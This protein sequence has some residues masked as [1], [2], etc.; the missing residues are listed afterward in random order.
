MLPSRLED[1]PTSLSKTIIT[2]QL[3][4][5]MPA[6]VFSGHVLHALMSVAPSTDDAVP[7]PQAIETQT[8]TQT[9]T[10]RGRGN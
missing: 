2:V 4:A 9:Q 6:Y 5:P 7:A 3:A 8:Q 1:R 10:Q